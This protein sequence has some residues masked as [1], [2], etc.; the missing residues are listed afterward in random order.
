MKHILCYG[1]SNTFGTNPGGGRWD[2]QTRWT[3]RL[4]TLLGDGYRVIE[5]G[6]G[7]RTTVWDDPLEP[8]RNGLAA[9]P[10]SLHSHRPLELV[11]LSLGTNDCKVHFNAT[12]RLIAKGA[13]KLIE[14][15]RTYRYGEGYPIPQILLVSP[16]HAGQDVENSQFASYDATSYEKS[17]RLAQFFRQTAVSAGVAFLDASQVAFPSAID[18]LHMD[19]EAHK[20]LAEALAPIIRNMLQ[21]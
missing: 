5:E 3:G 6:L 2:Y 10:I 18:Q 16:I 15:I 12:P 8:N 14:L 19:A 4:A 9:L 11:I 21:D 13:E 1:D 20:R 7:G 17:L